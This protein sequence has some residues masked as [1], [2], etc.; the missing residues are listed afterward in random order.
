M[1]ERNHEQAIRVCPV[2]LIAGRIGGLNQHATCRVVSSKADQDHRPGPPGGLSD[3]VAREFAAKLS[4]SGRTAV[5]ENRT[6]GGGTIGAEAAAKSLP[7]GYTLYM[8]FHATQ[9][10]LPHLM[11]RLSYDATKDFAPII[12]LATAPNVLIVHPSVPAK[13]VDELITYARA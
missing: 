13:T 5:V 9:S 2:S 11:P 4:E 6:G 7:D 8:G 10:I 1:E 3:I 12:L